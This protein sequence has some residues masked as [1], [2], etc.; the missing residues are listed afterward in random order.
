M[1]I[2]TDSF[3]YSPPQKPYLKIIYADSE[4][5]VVDKPSGL[6]AVP[7]R[8][9]E[10]KDS[11]ISRLKTLYASATAV[12][13]LDM[14]TSG[15]MV[16]ALSPVA[17]SG[18]GRAF[19]QRKVKKYYIAAV[20]GIPPRRGRII[21]PIR[22]DLDHRPLQ[23]VDYMMGKPSL[24]EFERVDGYNED[25]RSKNI[26]SSYVKL[27][28][29]TGR[30]HQLRLHLAT[31]GHPI[32]GDRFYADTKVADS[33]HRL[34]LHATYLAFKSSPDFLPVKATSCHDPA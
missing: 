27:F 32:L 20:A 25:S 16:V 31:I 33:S 6:L 26:C 22:A 30:S 19:E 1:Q 14:D 4:I 28:P 13:R 9:P 15:L 5:V 17:V 18:L 10:H 2:F 29:F 24:T 23:T 3:I 8:L 11:V 21:F 34:C 7:G 12:H